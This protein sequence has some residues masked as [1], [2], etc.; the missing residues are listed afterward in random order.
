STLDDATPC[1]RE[2]AM[3]REFKGKISLD[4]RDSTPDWGPF[5]QPKAPEGAP[6]V[7]MIV[8]DDVGYGAMEVHGGPIETPTMRRIAEVGIRY[9]NFHTTALCSPTRSSLL[10]GRN[11]TSN[12]MACITE[13]VQGFPGFSGR[14]PFEN[15][16]IAE[17]LNRSEERRVGKEWRKRAAADQHN[18]KEIEES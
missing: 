3:A 16:T 18:K 12:N 4:V 5:L 14:I 17:V 13:A 15:G 8:W 9:S 6:N 10:T 7:L 11:A 2:E 1:A